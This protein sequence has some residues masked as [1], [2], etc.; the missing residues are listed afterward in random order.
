MSNSSDD[1]AF[2]QAALPTM[3]QNYAQGS[4]NEADV[5]P[6]PFAQFE[7]WFAEA[8]SMGVVEP[9]AMILATA[10]SA[11]RPSARTMLL[12]GVDATGFVF[13]TNYDSRKGREIEINPHGAL[14]FFWQVIERQVRVEGRIERTSREDSDAYFHV[15]PLA[16]QIGAWASQQ[17]REIES[18]G[19]LQARENEIAARFSGMPVP[20]PDHWGGY[21]LIPHT[22]EFWQGRPGRLHDRLVYRRDGS[23][24][25]VLRRLQP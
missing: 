18:R 15:R 5:A 2:D 7:R 24:A 17:S 3:R 22:V 1:P 20:L 19:E 13:Y 9:N 25:W 16:S 14:V 4:L 23:G 12:K 10:D 8:R 6:E 21:R 11:G